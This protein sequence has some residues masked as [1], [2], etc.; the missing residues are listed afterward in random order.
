[1][2]TGNT[3]VLIMKRLTTTLTF[4][5]LAL[6]GSAARG[7]DNPADCAPAAP[8]ATESWDKC[9]QQADP[10]GFVIYV[11]QQTEREMAVAVPAS[12]KMSRDIETLIVAREGKRRIIAGLN[13]QLEALRSH[14]QKNCF[15]VRIGETCIHDQEQA[16]RLA[17]SLLCQ[18]DGLLQS[19]E[20]ISVQIRDAD[21]E[22]EQLARRIERQQVHR[23]LAEIRA[24]RIAVTLLPRTSECLN[25]AVV[26]MLPKITPEIEAHR[27]RVEEFLSS[28]P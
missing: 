1:M 5:A 14:V 2:E 15:P 12:V 26:A 23:L 11:A 21:S 27:K 9:R 7:E 6:A 28:N 13:S 24:D 8:A 22:R 25:E 19:V 18:L 16:T 3:G 10:V 20:Q 4:A 17:S